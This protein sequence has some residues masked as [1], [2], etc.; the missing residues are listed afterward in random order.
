[1]SENEDSQNASVHSYGFGTRSHASG[2]QS[3]SSRSESSERPASPKQVK[4]VDAATSAPFFFCDPEVVAVNWGLQRHKNP[5]RA[6]ATARICERRNLPVKPG[7]SD[8]LAR[9]EASLR[10]RDTSTRAPFCVGKWSVYLGPAFDPEAIIVQ[11]DEISEVST[12][13][14]MPVFFKPR[15]GFPTRHNFSHKGIKITMCNTM[16]WSLEKTIECE[17]SRPKTRKLRTRKERSIH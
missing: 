5:A 4:L 9:W 10:A 15:K 3:S 16:N 2:S 17:K 13:A 12:T 6:K 7:P 8:D 14:S 1:M 11:E